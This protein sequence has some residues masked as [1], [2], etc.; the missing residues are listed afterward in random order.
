MDIEIP[1][2]SLDDWL[3]ELK[4]YQR[5]SIQELLKN[6]DELETAEIWVSSHGPENTI[7]F[8]GIP[9]T[10]PF[11]DN[12]KKEFNRFICDDSAYTKERESLKSE[13]TI[14]KTL[15]I[16]AI[17][18]ALGAT[19]GFTA[20][21]LAPAIALLLFNVSKITKNAYCNTYFKKETE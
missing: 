21:L 2:G 14:P 1:N 7:P 4:P 10:K 20:T 15:M 3:S 8:G 19:L 9:N 17:S 13:S 5:N 11:W 16:S 6:H 18:A 12:L